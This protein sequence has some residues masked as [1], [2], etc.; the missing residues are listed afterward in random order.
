MNVNETGE[1]KEA[2]KIISKSMN[3]KY[4]YVCEIDYCV[5]C[6]R[7]TKRRY[8]VYTK[9]KQYFIWDEVACSIHFI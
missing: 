4:W 3:K 8:R 9:P 6:G 1:Y 5:L 2:Q 7:E